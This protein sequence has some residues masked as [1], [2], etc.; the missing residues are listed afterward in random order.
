MFYIL[1]T[2]KLKLVQKLVLVLVQKLPVDNELGP[3]WL[4]PGP[5]HVVACMQRK[6]CVDIS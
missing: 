5:R 6:I 2:L 3:D 1:K 4:E